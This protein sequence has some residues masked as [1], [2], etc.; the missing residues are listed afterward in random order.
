M[1]PPDDTAP[2]TSRRGLRRPWPARA[3]IALLLHHVAGDIATGRLACAAPG[4]PADEALD[5]EAAAELAT[6][7]AAHVLAARSRDDFARLGRE[8]VW[9]TEPSIAAASGVI[10]ALGDDSSA[11]RDA[12]V[13][14]A[15]RHEPE[16][17]ASLA[18]ITPTAR[19]V[20]VMVAARQSD[21]DPYRLIEAVRVILA[22]LDASGLPGSGG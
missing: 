18:R 8:T 1:S 4:A 11:G 14:S 17:R 15:L 22:F 13:L 9:L 3:A 12:A 6:H 5:E 20:A 19:A 21:G 10:E 16:I 7:L 2:E